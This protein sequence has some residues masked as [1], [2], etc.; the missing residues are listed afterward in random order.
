MTSTQYAAISP[1]ILLGLYLIIP[2]CLIVYGVDTILFDA[3]L[4]AVLPRSPENFFLVSIFLGAPHIIASNIILVTNKDYW[5]FYKKRVI[6]AAVMLGVL[7]AVGNYLLP[8]SAIFAIVASW[9]IMHVVKQQL[10]IGNGFYRLSP[11]LYRLWSTAIITLGILIYNIVFLG[12]KI[13]EPY[14]GYLHNAILFFA[15]SIVALTLI[16][17]P[18]V[19]TNFGKVFLWANTLMI[20]AS[21]WMF[22]EHC[23]FFTILIPRF[24]HDVTAFVFYAVHDHNKHHEVPQN[25]IYRFAK[26]L[27]MPALIMAPLTAVLLTVAFKKAFDPAMNQLAITLF[28]VHHLGGISFFIIGFLSLIHYYTE[29]FTWTVGSPYR[30]FVRFKK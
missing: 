2:A 13:A 18:R 15:T 3:S 21:L 27:K 1:R 26:K 28:D 10:G 8:Y 29:A 5:G 17:Y 6:I 20:F 12:D 4:K 16:A 7:L 22:Y 25:F 9:T 19:K 24:I 30:Q 23:F 14:L 11:L